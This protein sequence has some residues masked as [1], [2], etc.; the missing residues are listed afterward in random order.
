MC[1][2]ACVF[3][4]VR[5]CVCACVRVCVCAC[6][7]VCVC[8]SAC[9]R[10][11][12]SCRVAACSY[13]ASTSPPELACSGL[14]LHSDKYAPPCAC[15]VCCLLGCVPSEPAAVAIGPHKCA[16]VPAYVCVCVPTYVRVRVRACVRGAANDLALNCWHLAEIPQLEG[17]APPASR[18]CIATPVARKTRAGLDPNT[19]C[20]MHMCNRDGACGGACGPSARLALALAPA[21]PCAPHALSLRPAAHALASCLC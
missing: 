8:V 9:V 3:A 1:V 11:R 18:T 4:F 10:A 21:P 12:G 16:S 6:V 13:F 2:R 20:A 19:A 17:A 15:L 5:V 14:P 7:R